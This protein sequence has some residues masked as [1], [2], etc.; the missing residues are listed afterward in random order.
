MDFADLSRLIYRD[1]IKQKHDGRERLAL[2]LQG[3]NFPEDN[4]KAKRRKELAD[5]SQ[6]VDQV[7][8]LILDHL[9]AAT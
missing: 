8:Q 5:T 3:N 7:A 4:A 6:E 1:D 9:L 2:E